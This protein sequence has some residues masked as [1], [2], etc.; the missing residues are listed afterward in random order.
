MCRISITQTY[1]SKNYLSI[2]IVTY[3]SENY[4]KNCIYSILNSNLKNIKYKIIVI[5]N[6]SNDKTKK[7]IRQIQKTE[8]KLLL[9]ENVK[10]L[11]FAKAVNQG[12]TKQKNYEYILLLNPDTIVKSKSIINLINCSIVNNSGI[13]GG[14]T[15]DVNGKN[16]GSYFRFPNLWVG[17]FDFTNL[18]K[19][20]PKDKWHNYFYFQDKN[21]NEDISFPVDVITGGFMLLKKKTIENIG[22]F[23]ESYFMYLEDVDYCLKAIKSGIKIFHTNES[24]IMHIGGASSKN[25]DRVRHSSWLKSRKVYFIKHFGIIDNL[26]IQPI[27]LLDDLLILTKMAFKKL[28]IKPKL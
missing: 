13:C 8:N 15:K 2:I 27:F 12:I 25:E 17:L 18:R 23:D 16:S 7:I 1:M 3:N 24:S 10:N 9:I 4:I 22:L 14:I 19:I 21:C 11:G 5:D 6:S 26:I 20:F 28:S